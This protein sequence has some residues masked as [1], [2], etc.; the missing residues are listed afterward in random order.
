MPKYYTFEPCASSKG[1][2]VKFNTQL[3][4]EKIDLGEVIAETPVVKMVT[5]EGHAVSLYASGRAMFKNISRQEAETLAKKLY[6]NLKKGGA[7]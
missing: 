2:E 5:F 7:L 4:L 3:H 6:K 1:F